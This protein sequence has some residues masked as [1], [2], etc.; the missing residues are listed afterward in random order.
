MNRTL[1]RA[2]RSSAARATAA[3]SAPS[4]AARAAARAASPS[5]MPTVRESTTCTGTGASRAA[6]F[7]DVVVPESSPDRCTETISD[8][9]R[10][11]TRA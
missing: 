3:P 7:A 11:A 9:P 4:A 5:P 8:A 1:V 6:R 2:A 10:A